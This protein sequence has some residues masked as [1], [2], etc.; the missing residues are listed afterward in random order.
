VSISPEK[1]RNFCIVAHIDH[2]K[3]TLA[4]RFL[5][6]TKAID[7]KKMQAQVLD[8]MDLERER[9]ITIKAHAIS[10]DH[11]ARNGE[12]YRLNLIDT[13]GH[14]DF[15]YEVSRSL[16]SC[17]GAILLVDATQGIEAQ[18]VANLYLALESSLEIIPVINKVDREG[19]NVEEHRK[20]LAHLCGVE[21]EEV[22]AIS[23]KMGWGVA[24][25]LEKVIE[26]VPP[27]E[28]SGGSPL[29]ALIFDSE[30]D[31]Y[32]GVIS[33]V[34]MVDGRLTPGDRVRLLSTAR[35]YE[36][37]EVGE[38]RLDY[39][40]KASLTAGEVGYFIAGI[41]VVADSRV[42]DT[43]VLENGPAPQPLPGYKPMKPMVWCGFYPVNNDDYLPLK[44]G[45]A[46]LQLNDSALVYEPETS[47]A[48][49]FG[50]RCGFLGP[51][52]MEIVQER[53][54]R[55]FGVDLI[56]TTPNVAVKVTKQDSNET[57]LVEHP[58]KMPPPGRRQTVEE[59]YVLAHI[60]TPPEALGG[61]LKLVQERRGEQ[62][63]M[64][65]L[66]GGRVR[67]T[68]L[69]PFSEIALNFYDRLKSVS[70]GY[71]TLDYEFHGYRTSD[72]V[73]LDILLN[74]ETVDALSV[75]VH[76][77]KAYY[78]GRD[79]VDRLKNLIPRQLFP[80][81]IQAALGGKIIARANLPALR[82]DVLAKCYGGDVTRKR[83]LLERQ[84]EGKRRMKQV[85]SV[86][87]PQ[88][89]FLALLRP[90]EEK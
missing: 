16:A 22:H 70:R 3:S 41:K 48:L 5:E 17:E 46:K 74:G 11:K 10:M 60:Y 67:L 58:G 26:K 6:V 77:D 1:I 59:P 34:R 82:K 62:Q 24:E 85:G 78:V 84:K 20:D 23:A 51:L 44:D 68:Y 43:V 53:V 75:I 55:E 81:A 52:H 27:P 7:P 21:P 36:V 79:L 49:G 80:V 8:D 72:L 12:T 69:L 50:F 54:L 64:E 35:S 15:S 14:V 13:P 87:V 39:L 45:L 25:L 56:A 76:R 61:V 66:D 83:K 42:G 86:Q 18:T 73:R 47:T 30:Y 57:V 19:A 4:D 28:G 33:L 65:F 37:Q 32:R 31:S 40:P 71:A 90:R 88:E 38:M 2:G 89:A 9:G 63:S 29:R